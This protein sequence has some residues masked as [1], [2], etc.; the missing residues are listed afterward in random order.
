[1]L[2]KTTFIKIVIWIVVIVMIASIFLPY[3][4]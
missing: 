3:I 4:V 1:M 2:K